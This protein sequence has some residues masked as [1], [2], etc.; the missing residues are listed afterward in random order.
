MH[1]TRESK[2]L[3][4]KLFYNWVLLELFKGSIDQQFEVALTAMN[5]VIRKQW[6]LRAAA[7]EY[8]CQ[9]IE[10]IKS[11]QCKKQ[12]AQLAQVRIF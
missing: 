3:R 10:A 9:E 1:D 12:D 11:S 5:P 7:K 6:Q 2:A 4:D 8:H